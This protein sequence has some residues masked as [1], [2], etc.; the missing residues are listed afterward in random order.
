MPVVFGV[1]I[2]LGLVISRG[3]ADREKRG[4]KPALV[5]VLQLY[6]V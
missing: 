3:V 5:L 4:E 6:E 2:V 1:V